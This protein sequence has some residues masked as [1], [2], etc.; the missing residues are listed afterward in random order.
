M[1]AF[2]L[3]FRLA[4]ADLW[5]ERILTL[6]VVV[7]LTAVLSPLLILLSLKYGLVE[8]LR[9]RLIHDP[10]NREIRPQ[11][12]RIYTQ[13]DIDALRQRADVRYVMPQT[14]AIS[15]MVRVCLPGFEKGQIETEIQP[16]GSGDPLL[17]ENGAKAPET[18]QCVLSQALHRR[19]SA[20]GEFGQI[21][22]TVSRQGRAGF[23]TAATLLTVVGVVG[24]RATSRETIFVPLEFV[25]QIESWL[26]GHPVAALGWAGNSSGV[27]P[28]V[29][30][31]IVP[32]TR[33]LSP[34]EQAA[35]I[36]STG[37]SSYQEVDRQEVTRHLQPPEDAQAFY[38]FTTSSERHEDPADSS[39]LTRFR[40]SL[41]PVA[42]DIYGYC[43]PI[44][45]QLLLADGRPMRTASFRVVPEVVNRPVKK[46]ETPPPAAS[47][48][49]P[50]A[51][52]VPA[53]A[54]GADA[55]MPGVEPAPSKALP[56]PPDSTANETVKR[57]LPVRRTPSGIIQPLP[58]P[59]P[60]GQAP[61]LSVMPLPPA[62]AVPAPAAGGIIKLDQSVK[63]PPAQPSP[64]E[65][66]RSKPD[67]KG[68]DDAKDGAKQGPPKGKK[69]S[70]GFGAGLFS[71][72][73]GRYI[74]AYTSNTLPPETPP[75]PVLYLPQSWGVAAGQTL[76][77]VFTTPSG[78]VSFP[79]MVKLR[80][81][82]EPLLPQAVAGMLR[83]GL[84]RPIEFRDEAGTFVTTRRG[85]PNFRLVA[86]DIDGV[87]G[88]VDHFHSLGMN[89]ITKAERIRDVKELDK[90]TT[91]V[92]WLIAGV[93]LT[94]AVGALL[95]SLFA[96]VERKRRSLGVLRLL[97]LRRRSLMRLPFYQSTIIVSVSVG[98]AVAAWWWV[99]RFVGRFTSGYLEAG[100]QLATLP[101]EH[102]LILWAG[103]L[104]V[105]AFAAFFAGIRVMRVD[106]S[107]AIRDE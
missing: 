26:E 31:I 73:G 92:F 5:H 67:S 85:W 8:T 11:S 36:V 39:A 48:K 4:V 50:M 22:V 53:Q 64:A 45:L 23:E 12:T 15:T 94:G 41:P 75:P 79:A 80:E 107:E 10:R 46:P 18:A 13:A 59:G 65:T 88:L 30:E 93:G 1:P 71:P 51:R 106:P 44:S 69:R 58:D 27:S 68:D 42:G 25:E 40:N 28:V 60:G 14:R 57:P 96:A 49:T 6:C 82:E 20:D 35:L 97:G 87:Q 83:V 95:A 81:G 3:I 98:L 33:P 102:L 54:S 34:A 104:V 91:Q 52:S 17:E 2:A 19:L 105:A 89:V 99:S 24:E 61:N 70:S 43:R 9:A 47:V 32:T 78:P 101:R 38:R 56:V 7:A 76:T 90:Y 29:E 86:R 72:A 66:R 74:M 62:Q 77:A 55:V 103:A 84:D 21:L 37:F 100:E 63:P 16:T